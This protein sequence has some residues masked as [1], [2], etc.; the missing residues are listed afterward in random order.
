LPT[1]TKEPERNEETRPKTEKDETASGS[2][3]VQ[4]APG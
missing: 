1:G 2:V 3:D 4:K